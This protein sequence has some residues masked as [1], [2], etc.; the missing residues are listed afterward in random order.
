VSD[1][2]AE[3]GRW[4]QRLSSLIVKGGVVP[5][6]S[7][8]LRHAG[9][10]GLTPQEVVLVL[11]ILDKKWG[12]DW[13]YVSMLQAASEL[14]RHKNKVY[15]W[16]QSLVQKGFLEST[17]RT[18]PGVGRRADYCDLSGLFAAL[19]R[20]VLQEA[21]ENARGEIPAP[22]YDVGGLRELSTGRTTLSGARRSPEN[23]ASGSNENGAA[24]ITRTGATSSNA[25]GA[26]KRSTPQKSSE[27]SVH[28]KPTREEL[29]QGT[30]SAARPTAH[31]N[32]KTDVEQLVRQYAVEFRD[33]DVDRSVARA[34]HVWWNSRLPQIAFV[35]LVEVARMR[36][37]E[38]MSLGG[39]KKGKPGAR[40]AMAYFFGV[41]EELVNKELGRLRTVG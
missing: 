24:R 32:V 35:A 40:A 27:E 10:L 9:E 18:V 41:L 11:Y 30:G 20:L 4:E 2:T 13:P 17:P 36:T 22:S 39:I 28:V 7:V 33:D 12:P 37:K 5:T 25:M 23:G 19:E 15:Q 3:K 31:A 6:P 21:I 29:T 1:Q 38:Q 26:R 34:Q 8:L 14:G 16:K